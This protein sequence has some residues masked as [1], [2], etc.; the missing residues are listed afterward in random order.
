MCCL[1]IL[2]TVLALPL[3]ATAE[4]PSQAPAPVPPPTPGAQA[5]SLANKLIVVDPG[6]G[7]PDTGTLAGTIPEKH[8][9][10]AIA[11]ALKRLLEAAGARTVYTRTSD[12]AVMSGTYSSRAD[13]QARLD[14]ANRSNADLFV[15]IHADAHV[16]QAIAGLTVYY[17]STMATP[18]PSPSPVRRNSSR[19]ATNWPT[20]C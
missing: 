18:T 16:D 15:S 13:L 7:G 8:V 5:H 14:V 10:L 2:G 4:P 1:G 12:R 20:A 11:M 3:P 17:G 6:H 9:N 19:P